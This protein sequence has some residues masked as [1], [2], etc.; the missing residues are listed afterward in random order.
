MG[1][2]RL[3]PTRGGNRDISATNV[4]PHA[5]ANAAAWL[6]IPAPRQATPQA[7]SP[8]PPARMILRMASQ[9]RRLASGDRACARRAAGVA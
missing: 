7:N 9:K 8:K 3:R 4:T 5:T 1:L 6:S 2:F